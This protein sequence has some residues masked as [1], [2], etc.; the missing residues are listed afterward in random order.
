MID[1][2]ELCQTHICNCDRCILTLEII[3]SSQTIDILSLEIT[4][5]NINDNQP[6]FP[7]STF[8]IR[9]SENTDIGHI[10][11]FPSATD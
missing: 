4:I 11:S 10:S 1:R 3:A 6:T 5:E 2:E 8:Q 9:L 7:V